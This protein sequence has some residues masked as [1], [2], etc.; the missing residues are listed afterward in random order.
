MQHLLGG[1]GGPRA[2]PPLSV[3]FPTFPKFDDSDMI[4]NRAP[5]PSPELAFRPIT[6]GPRHDNAA[7]EAAVKMEASPVP[8]PPPPVEEED[9]DNSHE[10]NMADEEEGEEADEEAEAA[11]VAPSPALD[12]QEEPQNLSNKEPEPMQKEKKQPEEE[13]EDRA[14]VKTPRLN[15]SPPGLF[16][17]LP[18]EHKRPRPPFFPFPHQMAGGLFRPQFLHGLS[19]PMDSKMMP[20]IFPPPPPPPQP[21]HMHMENADEAWENFIEIDKEGETSKL[22]HLV[23]TLGHK[24]SDPNECIVC[25]KVLSCKSALQMH[26]RTHTGE[27]PYRCKICKRGFTTKGNLKTHMSV[28]QIRAP[29]RAFHQCLICQKRYPNALVL[30]EHIKTHS[31]APTEL[32]LDQISAA[33]IKDFPHFGHLMG[34]GGGNGGKPPLS[35][36]FPGLPHGASQYSAENLFGF[37]AS[38]EQAG[39]G[40]RRG[41]KMEDEE[42]EDMMMEQ[43]D[44]RSSG[45]FDASS[46]ESSHHSQAAGGRPLTHSAGKIHFSFY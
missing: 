24:L 6:L 7:S 13:E 14:V 3:L 37:A 38:Y 32:T 2:P 9:F 22:E 42:D 10:D 26:Y 25:H 46:S 43:Q 5:Q 19:L 11:R 34:G 4:V 45:S 44:R 23:N 18:Q 21:T 39:S 15:N 20:N 33:E 27:R 12:M 31:G 17:M 30:Q 36:S 28:H 35:L 16:H 8:P 29:V 1:V 41:L 40:G